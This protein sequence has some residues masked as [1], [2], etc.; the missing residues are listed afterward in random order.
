MEINFTSNII[1]PKFSDNILNLLPTVNNTLK[2][3]MFFDSSINELFKKGSGIKVNGYI[4]KKPNWYN[5]STD[6]Y[7]NEISTDRNIYQLEPTMTVNIND[8]Y[9][10]AVYFTDYVD[11][12]SNKGAITEDQNR[13]FSE[14]YYTYNIPINYDM[15]FNYSNYYHSNDIKPDYILIDTIDTKNPWCNTI[16]KNKSNIS[17]LTNY[18]KAIRPIIC[19]NNI[20]LFQYGEYRRQAVDFVNTDILDLDSMKQISNLN[21]NGNSY[22]K[23]TIPNGKISVLFTGLAQTTENNMVY[24]IYFDDAGLSVYEIKTDGLDINGLPSTYEVIFDTNTSSDYYYKDSSWKL[25]QKKT[26]LNQAP[27]FLLYDENG[28]ELSDTSVYPNSTFNGS[29]IFSYSEDETESSVKDTVLNL[30]L[31]Y[32]S[33]GSIMFENNIEK[34]KFYYDIVNEITSTFFYGNVSIDTDVNINLE[35]CWNGSGSSTQYIKEYF[36]YDGTNRIFKLSTNSPSNYSVV[37]KSKLIDNDDITVSTSLVNN[38]DYFIEDDNLLL[39]TLNI[40]D[41]VEISYKS[42]TFNNLEHYYEYPLSISCNPTYEDI[43]DISYQN[44]TFFHKN[45]TFPRKSSSNILLEMLLSSDDKIDI[46]SSIQYCADQYRIYMFRFISKLNEYVNSGLYGIID[47]VDGVVDAILVSITKGLT[48]ASPFFNSGVGVSDSYT[49]DYFIPPTPSFV[50]LFKVYKPVIDIDYTSTTNIRNIFCHDGSMIPA[51]GDFRDNVILNLQ[52]RIYLSIKDEFKQSPVI[53]ISKHVSNAFHTNE[54][55]YAEYC[56]VIESFFTTWCYE[57]NLDYKVNTTY[58]QANPMTYN[59]SSMTTW[60]TNTQLLGGW[61]GIY[62][63]FYGTDRPHV[64]PWECLGFSEKPDYWDGVYGPAP[65]TYGNKKLWKDI[66]S[67]IIDQNGTVD[68]SKT[69]TNLIY[70]IPVDDNGDLVDPVKAN[71]LGTYPSY[72][73]ASDSWTFGDGSPIETV[74]MR[75]SDYPFAAVAAMYLMKPS[76]FINTC[77]DTEKTKNATALVYDNNIKYSDMY[78]HGETYNKSTVYKYG[79]Q[80]FVSYNIKGQSHNIT[81]V[82]GEKI[83][84]LGI[85]LAYRIGGFTNGSDIVVNSDTYGLLPSENYNVIQYNSPINDVIQYS[86]TLI[87]KQ[88]AGWK[89]YGYDQISSG[90]KTFAPNTNT[91]GTLIEVKNVSTFRTTY[92]AKNTKYVKNQIVSYNGKT[93]DCNRNHTSGQFFEIA[94]W[95]EVSDQMVNNNSVEWYSKY[96]STDVVSVPFGNLYGTYQEVSDLMCGIDLYHRYNGI[97]F[98]QTNSSKWYECVE[99]FINWDMT[100]EKYDFIVLSPLSD[101]ITMDYGFGNVLDTTEMRDG[102]WSVLDIN[103]KNTSDFDVVRTASTISII[104][105]SNTLC[106]CNFYK[107]TIEHILIFDNKTIFDDVIFSPELCISQMRLHIDG[108]K[109]SDWNGRISAGGFII[110]GNTIIPNYD[111]CA[112][113]F[114][115]IY[116]VDSIEYDNLQKRGRANVGFYESDTLANLMVDK[117]NQFEIYQSI[118]QNKGTASSFNRLLRSSIVSSYE[119]ISFYEEWA[120][121][122]GT[123]GAERNFQSLD[124]FLKQKDITNANQVIE[125]TTVDVKQTDTLGVFAC[126]GNDVSYNLTPSSSSLVNSVMVS[127][128]KYDDSENTTIYIDDTLIFGPVTEEVIGNV[129]IDLSAK[130]ITCSTSSVLKIISKSILNVS[131]SITYTD[132]F[133][134]TDNNIISIVDYVDSSNN[135]IVSMDDRWYLRQFDVNEIEF[136]KKNYKL[137]NKNFLKTSGYVNLDTVKW[138]ASNNHA[139]STLYQT[140]FNNIGSTACDQTYSFT[141]NSD[142]VFPTLYKIISST[143]SGYFRL[144]KITL[145]VN[146]IFQLP[147]VVN[148]GT[149]SQLPDG[150]K[151]NFSETAIERITYDKFGA[152]GTYEI[153]PSAIVYMDGSDNDVYVQVCSD[154]TIPT[155]IDLGNFTMNFDIEYVSDENIIPGDRVWVYDINNSW[156]TYK[157]IDTGLKVYEITP[158]TS[159]TP[160]LSLDNMAD[161]SSIKNMSGN[162]VLSGTANG[163]IDL[164]NIKPVFQNSKTVLVSGN[165][166]TTPLYTMNVNAGMKIK[167]FN[168]NI[169]QPFSTTDESDLDFQIGDIK[170]LNYIADSYVINNP[171][172]T[173][174]SLSSVN[175]ITIQAYNKLVTLLNGSPIIDLYVTRSGNIFGKVD[176]NGNVLPPT[177]CGDS[178]TTSFTWNLYNVNDDGKI[179]TISLETGTYSFVNSQTATTSTIDPDYWLATIQVTL[180]KDGNYAFVISNPSGGT[181]SQDTTL[182]EMSGTSHSFNLFDPTRIGIQNI[183]PDQL[184]DNANNGTVYATVGD[185]T[186]GT[187]LVNITYEYDNGFEISSGG[188]TQSQNTFVI[189]TNAESTTNYIRNET[190]GVITGNNDLKIKCDNSYVYD[191]SYVSNSNFVY[192]GN[193]FSWIPSRYRT[194]NDFNKN[195]SYF[196]KGD[197][198]EIDNI[199]GKWNICQYD[200]EKLQSIISQPEFVDTG[201]IQSAYLYNVDTQIIEQYMDIYDPMKGFIQGNLKKELDYISNNNPA[202]YNNSEFTNIQIDNDNMWG[203]SQVGEYWWN[204]KTSPYLVYEMNGIDGTDEYKIKNWGSFCPGVSVDVYQWIKSPVS[205]YEY[206]SYISS[207]LRYDGFDSN[208]TGTIDDEISKSWVQK[209]EWDN[210]SSSEITV[211]YFWVKNP[212]TTIKK[213]ISAYEISSELANKNNG[214]STFSV[215]DRNKIIISGAKDFVTDSN[216]TL[217]I[218]WKLKDTDSNFHKEWTLI[219]ENYSEIPDVLWNKMASSLVGYDFKTENKTF[220]TTLIKDLM[221]NDS[222]AFIDSTNENINS[223][224]ISSD[225]KIGNQWYS[226]GNVIGS[227]LSGII[228]NQTHY[229]KNTPVTFIWND[230]TAINVPSKSLNSYQQIG[231]LTRPNQSWFKTENELSSRSARKIFVK[232]LNQYFE[233]NAVIDNWYENISFFNSEDEKP[234]SNVYSWETDNI[235]DLLTFTKTNNVSYNDCILVNGID[236][237]NFWSLWSYQP[238]AT[239]DNGGFVIVECQKWRMLESE[240]WEYA[241]WYADGYSEK[242]YPTYIFKNLTER[243]VAIANIDVTLLYGTLVKVCEINSTNKRWAWYSYDGTTWTEVAKQNATIVLSDAFYKNT[244]VHSLDTFD[245]TLINHRDGTYELSLLLSNLRNL[246]LTDIEQNQ[247]FFEMVKYAISKTYQNDWVFKTSLLYIGGYVEE[248]NQNS[249]LGDDKILY[250]EDFVNEYKPYHVKIRDFVYGYTNGIDTT[251]I[252][253]SDY[254]FPQ[255]YDSSIK[256]YRNLYPYFIN[257]QYPKLN[258]YKNIDGD[259]ALVSNNNPWKDWYNAFDNIGLYVDNVHK[260]SE[261]WNPVRKIETNVIFDRKQNYSNSGW[262]SGSWDAEASYVCPYGLLFTEITNKGILAYL[263]TGTYDFNQNS[264]QYATASNFTKYSYNLQAIG[265]SKQHTISFTPMYLT[266]SDYK[267]FRPDIYGGYTN[268]KEVMRFDELYSIGLDNTVLDGTVCYVQEDSAHYVLVRNILSKMFKEDSTKFYDNWVIT[269]DQWPLS[270]E[271]RSMSHYLGTSYDYDNITLRWLNPKITDSCYYQND[272]SSNQYDFI[273][274]PYISQGWDSPFYEFDGAAARINKFYE[275]DYDMISVDEAMENLGGNEY[276]KNLITGGDFDTEEYDIKILPVQ[277]ELKGIVYPS[278]VEFSGGEIG[279]PYNG[280]NCNPEELCN[281]TIRDSFIIDIYEYQYDDT[282]L[283]L[284]NKNTK[285]DIQSNGSTLVYRF[286]KNIV[287]DFI[288]YDYAKIYKNYNKF[289]GMSGINILP[290]GML[291]YNINLT[292]EY[293]KQYSDSKYQNTMPT[294]VYDYYKEF[295]DIADFT[296]IKY[297]VNGKYVENRGLAINDLVILVPNDTSGFFCFNDASKNITEV[298]GVLPFVTENNFDEL[299]DMGVFDDLSV[300]L[301]IVSKNDAETEL[302]NIQKIQIKNKVLSDNYMWFGTELISFSKYEDITD[303]LLPNPS[304]YT[305]DAYDPTDPV[306]LE[307]YNAMGLSKNYSY[308]KISDV[309]RNIGGTSSYNQSVIELY[310]ELAGTNLQYTYNE[311]DNT[312]VNEMNYDIQEKLYG[313]PFNEYGVGTPSSFFN[314][315]IQAVYAGDMITTKADKLEFK[316][317]TKY[318]LISDGNIENNIIPALT[319]DVTVA[320]YG[321]IPMYNTTSVLEIKDIE[322]MDRVKNL[323][324]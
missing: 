58:N 219:N 43:T 296:N 77:W 133:I 287:G 28:N 312:Q 206:E 322:M 46:I 283:Q 126:D 81:D 278:E 1:Q 135:E 285:I 16:W 175:P 299:Y 239:T 14:E 293:P 209:T 198:V 111:T 236:S 31:N 114:R 199:D 184:N 257:S 11:N 203:N 221:P 176:K 34:D 120:F 79:V 216:T 74:W 151:N 169:I 288:A 238:Y 190:N 76:M 211:Y 143:T 137:K 249:I 35:T 61:R 230:K 158:N 59:W 104:S 136:K 254:D 304:Y 145:T 15:F 245:K 226:Y 155:G 102:K 38:V 142:A 298:K 96:V 301:N 290:V 231:C 272:F 294:W 138:T 72:E 131:L 207:D 280:N 177:D 253:V 85:N 23:F 73:K 91:S 13:L 188:I 12:L 10:S 233:N 124:I 123:Y 313:T 191:S 60:A 247:L 317:E 244:Y 205:P 237:N 186:I 171:V 201:L 71:L 146:N 263:T 173:V 63:Y 65:Y 227:K 307:I 5:S 147:I 66:S 291:M 306:Q 241:D 180:P 224:P 56:S 89:I 161:N 32:D 108:Y 195:A 273:W 192:G 311:V 225:V 121:R 174:P 194:V 251:N 54:Y 232:Y 240:L 178:V 128:S 268:D 256:S 324:K 25:C 164:N 140:V 200:G 17:D 97:S 318:N 246:F 53:D 165:N 259:L 193:I 302:S 170:N 181:I 265:A 269:V 92:W 264:V 75:S 116:D 40:G 69:R 18:S 139:F 51:Y 55:S 274:V 286:Y 305:N 275:P 115:Y 310:M 204:T 20:K 24:E 67:G 212:T 50:G 49:Q 26:K 148:I 300:T 179:G 80:Q 252:H 255:Y 57:N 4:G 242:N 235:S 258:D 321:S 149:K 129:T 113:N 99:Q 314:Y 127:I 172:P 144:N 260:Y 19:F 48:P 52:N 214:I 266:S 134:E 309:V 94:Y 289:S 125:F 297:D 2:N 82:L 187:A 229:L 292:P 183:S 41:E 130:N 270:K 282:Q 9:V 64:A 168:I 213:D 196:V 159:S 319:D 208:P 267:L 95:A 45:N 279:N 228:G 182:I 7:V 105:S 62:R 122:V 93:Y 27:L 36:K 42:S 281:I 150:V 303:K 250:I 33:N 119:D 30:H 323:N 39:K 98:D 47:D 163:N 202:I 117:T 223:M 37:L 189:S 83:R 106:G 162:I 103:N 29:K 277:M 156:N 210:I 234:A 107:N 220:T 86:A 8:E 248:F 88:D 101:N 215:I 160:V 157:L 166:K 217:K 167:S 44:L 84:G 109:T 100:A 22:N 90:F 153:Y 152:E 70:Y 118:I 197:Y 3:Q 132:T 316:T 276:G 154:Q 87:V 315:P 284:Y 141:L 21:I 6:F 295:P 222:V 112:D 271:D 320:Y 110:S 78:V 308:Y 185:N 68:K 243:D 218:N 262:D 261:T